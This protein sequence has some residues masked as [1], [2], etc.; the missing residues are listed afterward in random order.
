[1]QNSG[2]R[3]ICERAPRHV[4]LLNTIKGLRNNITMLAV[5]IRQFRNHSNIINSLLN[6]Q[7]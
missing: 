3:F 1:M 6:V 2:L 4:M 5:Q 7:T